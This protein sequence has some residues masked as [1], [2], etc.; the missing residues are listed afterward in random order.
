MGIECSSFACARQGNYYILVAALAFCR[1]CGDRLRCLDPPNVCAFGERGPGNSLCAGYPGTWRGWAI[2]CPHVYI[3]RD[4]T[5][6][7]VGSSCIMLVFVF[8]FLGILIGV[9]RR[10]AA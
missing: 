3:G 6:A 10:Y 7:V 9:I 8:V 4:G 1:C 2:S 5:L